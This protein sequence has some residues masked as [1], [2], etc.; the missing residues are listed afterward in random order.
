MSD[1]YGPTL[2]ISEEVHSLK[3]RVG[4]ETFK[5]AMARV[6][7][8]LGD[9]QEHYEKFKDILY[10]MRFM[11]AG[12]VQ[13]SMGAPRKVASHNCFVSGTIED[14]MGSIMERAAQAAETMRMGGGIG[15][16]FSKLRPKG[17]KIKSLDS[18]SSGPL[19]FMQVFDAI[20]GTV[21]SA[22]HR[23][24][25]QMGTMRIDHPD[26]EDFITVKNN[27]TAL[28]NFNLSVLITDK[29]MEAVV[30]G[31][32]FDLVFEGRDYREVDAR[33]LWDKLM[34]S[35]WEWAE[36]G[37][38]F[39]DK[40]NRKN[41]LHYIEDI[42]TSN[43]CAEQPLPPFGACLLGSFNLVKYLDKDMIGHTF[44]F[45]KFKHDIPVVVRA[46]DM[47][48]DK[49]VYPLEEQEQ[50]AKSKRR[51]GLGVTGVANALE[52]MG[53]KYGSKDSVLVFETIM[54]VLRDTA[55]RA[56]ISLATEKG[57]FPLYDDQYLDS[58]F[59][60]SLPGDIREDIRTYGIRNSH[61]LSVA[62]TGTISL[63]ADNVS[64]GI[65]PVFSH[66]YDRTINTAVG[67]KVERVEDYAYRTHGV[68][69]VTAD[70]LSPKQHVNMLIAASRYV[71]SAC[72]KTCNIGSDVSWEDFKQVYMDAW[73]GGASGCTTFRAAGKRFG[74]LNASASEDVVVEPE[75][76]TD[77][78]V[79][80]SEGTACYID[81]STGIR[82]C[83]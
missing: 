41:N 47:V 20:C 33:A 45:D 71:D 2:Q 77:D 52:I 30:S 43:P 10:D 3:Y 40:I 58:D 57:P 79:S 81:L 14:S 8:S 83:E 44:N 31:D 35:T 66:Y 7:D 23:R 27:T 82:T 48:V 38:L 28:T 54:R 67:T 13:A 63:S 64:S 1:T 70:Q 72:S 49:A 12:R 4:N 37:V 26:I 55:Y 29:F 51:M 73:L 74:I 56:S 65:E 53:F 50:E 34:R 46:M 5:G 62:P 25:A 19:S 76:Q 60:I 16:D 75:A 17:D 6:A 68:E 80:E 42:C 18:H 21:S 9:G 11:P 22:G 78:F 36:P 39:I 32:S 61:L 15:Y 59:A 69:G 24:G